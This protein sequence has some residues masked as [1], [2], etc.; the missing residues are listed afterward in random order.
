[1]LAVPAVRCSADRCCSTTP[2][3][4]AWVRNARA[5]PPA[6]RCRP[7]HLRDRGAPWRRAVAPHHGAAPWGARAAQARAVALAR[8]SRQGDRSAHA[9]CR[10]C[11]RAALLVELTRSSSSLLLFVRILRS[12]VS[13]SRPRT[14]VRVL[15]ADMRVLG[16]PVRPVRGASRDPQAWAVCDLSSPDHARISRWQLAAV[17]VASTTVNAVLDHDRV[18]PS[19]DL[20][21]RPRRACPPGARRMPGRPRRGRYA[22]R[23]PW[24][25]RPGQR[26]PGLSERLAAETCATTNILDTSAHGHA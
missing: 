5:R 20:P 6:R 3:P 15:S 24:A 17:C 19:G 26:G 10:L 23:S 1:M 2:Q 22:R 13:G 14:T 25:R 12:E 18:R 8:R 16:E 21:S 9:R 11:T 4:I 7:R